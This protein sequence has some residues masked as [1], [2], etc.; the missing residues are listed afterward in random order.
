ML[1]IGLT[2]GVGSGKSAISQFL[3]KEYGAFLINTDSLGH[4]VKL[5]GREAYEPIIDLFGREILDE[6]GLIDKG[7]LAER[8]FV[9]EPLL[10]KLNAIIHPAVIREVERQLAEKRQ[11]KSCSYAVVETALLI[12]SGLGTYCDSVWY[13]YAEEA[14]R[15]ERLRQSRGYSE[16]RIQA[17]FDRQKTDAEFRQAADVIIDNSGEPE[18]TEKQIRQHMR[19]LEEP[20]K[21]EE[22]KE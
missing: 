10:Q 7:K 21:P 5:P 22:R 15:R 6:Q 8:V 12:E 19:E 14:I 16:E 4:E 9:S 3:E 2:G 20:G 13:V 17:V 1:V 11:E 18:E